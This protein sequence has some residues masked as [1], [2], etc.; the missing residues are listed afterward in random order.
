VVGVELNPAIRS[1]VDGRG[2]AWN[3]EE[4]L[5]KDGV[6]LRIEEGR[7][8]LSR[9]RG[10]YDLI[11][12]ASN[13]AQYSARTGHSRKFLDTHEA[14]AEYFEHLTPNGMVLFNMQDLDL[15]LESW[16][17]LL[18]DAGL[19]FEEAVVL[20]G[21]KGAVRR[22][23]RLLVKPSGFTPTEVA[24]FREIWP[25]AKKRG[26]EAVRYAPGFTPDRGTLKKIQ[27]PVD[28]DRFVPTDDLPYPRRVDIKGWTPSPDPRRF[29]NRLYAMSWIKVF[30]LA[31]FCGLSLVLAGLFAGR[32]RGGLRLPVGWIGWFGTSGVAYMLVQV[33]LMGKLDLFLGSPLAAIALVLAAFLL[34]NGA[35]SAWYERRRS[36]GRAPAWAL[37]A[38]S[39][40]VAAPLTLGL[41]E[42]VMGV[43]IGLPTAIKIGIAFVLVAPVAFVLG[44]FYPAGVS[45]NVDRGR[46]ALVPMTFG[47]ATLSSVVGST[48]AMVIVINVGFRVLIWWAAGLYVLIAVAALWAGRRE[49][50]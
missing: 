22:W 7:G 46:Q 23:S 6:D 18:A 25:P 19:S 35:G 24:R 32:R 1:L 13:G 45:A 43:A 20:S 48:F 37:L 39:A 14:M 16:K 11:F 33:G 3:Q 31:L 47:L 10:R 40:A 28:L 8:F 26:D 9:D 44:T 21:R 34:S 36:A 17:R 4:F 29:T 38:A 49:A 5:A 30:T 15:K 2:G 50:V 12:V 42:V 27:A 41:V